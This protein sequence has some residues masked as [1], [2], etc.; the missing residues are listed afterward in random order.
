MVPEDLKTTSDFHKKCESKVIN[1]SRL[2]EQIREKDL[3]MKNI[4]LTLVNSKL[5]REIEMLSIRYI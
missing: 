2:K 3:N 4:E 5:A 1:T